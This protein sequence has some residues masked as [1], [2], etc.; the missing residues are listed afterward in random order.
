MSEVAI[1][2]MS[3]SIAIG[4]AFLLLNLMNIGDVKWHYKV[5]K[6]LKSGHYKYHTK[7]IEQIILRR[8]DDREEMI[9]FGDGS[10]KVKDDVYIHKS[11]LWMSVFNMYYYW[12]FH[13]LKDKLIKE[14]EL[15]EGQRTRAQALFDHRTKQQ[16]INF[17]FF[18]G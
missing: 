5:A 16:N 1:L 11:M 3:F 15:I 13:K 9:F 7:L 17:K 8:L 6:E 12:K 2:S 18:R 4:M 14:Y 10:I